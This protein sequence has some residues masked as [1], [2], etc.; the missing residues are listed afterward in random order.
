MDE[1]LNTGKD[2]NQAHLRK[3]N[4]VENDSGS[5]SKIVPQKNAST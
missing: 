5:Q 2:K 1:L 4:E 3:I